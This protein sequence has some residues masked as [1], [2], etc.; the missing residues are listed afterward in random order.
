[1]SAGV[2]IVPA[3]VN[4]ATMQ[5]G[6]GP[7]LMPSGDYAADLA[8]LAEFYLSKI[9]GHPKLLAL[10]APSICSRFRSSQT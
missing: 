8:R 2:P 3:W 5:G 9:P 4:N 10:A 7:A 1:M 6:V